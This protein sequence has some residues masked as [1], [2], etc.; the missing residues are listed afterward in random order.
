MK[1]VFVGK[2][3]RGETLAIIATCA[4]ILDDYAQ[5]GY[6][7]TVRQLYYQLV[8]RDIIPNTQQSYSRIGSIINDAR[9]A[10]LLDWDLIV[11]R[12][13]ETVALSH[14][15][16]PK[17]IIDACVRSFRID[18]WKDQPI[19]VEVMCEKQALEGVLQPACEKWDVP[20]TSN[21]GYSS[22]SFM[23]SKGVELRGVLN[24][25]I[26]NVH[27]LYYGDHD[28]SGLDMDRDIWERLSMFS[29]HS[30][31]WNPGV[32]GGHLY[33]K[34][35]ALTRQQIDQHSP[36][37]NPAKIT[38]SRAEGYIAQHGHDSWELDA[39]E[40]RTLVD[41]IDYEV[42][43]LL[44]N[45]G[46]LPLWEKTKEMQEQMREELAELGDSVDSDEWEARMQ[47]MVEDNEGV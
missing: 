47:Q 46:S 9:M 35:L 36:P 28:P 24:R 31:R 40:P 38:D 21:K 10:G 16:T 37:P 20:F 12:G 33:V 6:S 32:S 18:R 7:L 26:R 43:Q 19:H 4:G 39:L 29:H 15:D 1:E 5:E 41:I 30:A 14:W 13:R 25:Q 42:L 45:H 11:D 27:I 17:D 44:E 23:Y 3:F 8:A 22:Q 2:K 34:R